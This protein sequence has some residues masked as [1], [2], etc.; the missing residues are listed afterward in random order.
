MSTAIF[1]RKKTRVYSYFLY[2]VSF[3]GSRISV[4]AFH[5]PDL[6]AGISATIYS[7]LSE[8]PLAV[9]IPHRY[10]LGLPDVLVLDG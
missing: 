5:N 9:G 2:V 10:A 6:K 8:F 4:Q 7:H 3:F 1:S